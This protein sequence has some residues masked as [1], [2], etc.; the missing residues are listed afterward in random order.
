MMM[1]RNSFPRSALALALAAPLAGAPLAARAQLAPDAGRALG[2]QRREEAR[3]LPK[4]ALAP[5]SQR[6]APA[7]GSP[8]SGPSA[9]THV[10]RF[11][12]TE[13]TPTGI[14]PD[15]I[16]AALAPFEGRDLD[17]AGIEAA[18]DALARLYRAEGF[19]L[20]Q[21]YAPAQ[22]VAEGVVELRALPGRLESVEA[23]MAPGSRLPASRA[24]ALLL[25]ATGGK[26]SPSQPEIERGLLLLNEIPGVSARGEISPGETLGS[27]RLTAHVSEPRA[28]E[29]LVDAD[30]YGNRYTGAARAGAQISLNDPLGLGDSAY[31]RAQG[32]SGM[33]SL[34][35]GYSALVGDSGARAGVF[36]QALRYHLG[37]ELSALG[38]RG[39]A[40]ELGLTASYPLIRS[41]QS[42]LSLAASLSRRRLANEANGANVSDKTLDIASLTLSGQRRDSAWLGGV[43]QA[44]ATLSGG[45]VDLSGNPLD[46]AAD[47]AFAKTAG[48]YA[49]LGY[50]ISRLQALSPSVDLLARLSG[51]LASKNLDSSEQLTLGGPYGVRGYPVGE[52]YGDQGALAT[53]EARWSISP[54]WRAALFA[55]AGSIAPRKTPEPGSSA[56]ARY[57]LASAGASIEALLP[58]GLTAKLSLARAIGSNP[59]RSASGANADGRSRSYQVWMGLS[60]SF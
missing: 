17:L 40:S 26:P 8:S 54:M 57:T 32:S 15:R 2:E 28:W 5:L 31:A 12:A 46:Q 4:S 50:S 19:F 33:A 21:V 39:R 47:A 11:N 27:V 18:A 29:G 53:L 59:G 24:R 44:Q 49:R 51:Q 25:S 34:N 30:N 48:S 9:K 45:R 14:P 38:A 22:E 23:R 52:A 43:T 20:A 36:A 1:K 7:P 13:D 3:A 10:E 42:S 58:Q 60:K 6:A 37:E 56:R 55:D 16:R 35:A 41:T